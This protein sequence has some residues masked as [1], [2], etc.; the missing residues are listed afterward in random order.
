M[1]SAAQIAA[2]RRNA[3]KSTGPRTPGGKAVSAQNAWRHGLTAR[4]VAV[5]DEKNQDYEE[6]AA[7]LRDSLAPAD[8][9]EALLA[10]RIVLLSWRLRRVARAERGMIEAVDDANLRYGETAMSRL[11]DRA[12]EELTALSRYEM[13]L[14][15]ALGRA[16]ALL[17][18]RQARR[19]GAAVPPPITVIVESAGDDAEAPPLENANPLFPQ[20]DFENCETNPI[21][22]AEAQEAPGALRLQESA[23]G[24]STEI[25]GEI[26]GAP[27]VAPS[28]TAP[29][30]DE[31][32]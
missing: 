27:A 18:R 31:S 1:S 20:A 9:V 16:Y 11:F 12:P 2:N 24:I 28:F 5:S 17:E 14:D 10:E 30:R 25:S 15:R 29:P 7:A 4:Q 13:G 21:T 23:A 3:R 22:P 26:A 6:F 32:G 19:G 8:E